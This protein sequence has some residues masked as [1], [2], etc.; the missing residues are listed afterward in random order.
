MV[1]DHLGES[2]GGGHEALEDEAAALHHREPQG[3]RGTH[4]PSVV[5][6]RV[7]D[8]MGRQPEGVEHGLA[9]GDDRAD[10]GDDPLGLAGGTAGV[11]QDRGFPAAH[12][13]GCKLVDVLSPF[14]KLLF[15]PSNRV[16]PEN[17]PVR[18]HGSP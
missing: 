5:R 11:A 3:V 12:L 13:D 8:L 16:V 14:L 10:E 2:P 1:L 15:R 9:P 17:V 4:D 7:V 18:N 6:G